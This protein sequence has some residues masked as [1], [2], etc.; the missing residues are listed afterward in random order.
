MAVKIKVMTFNLRIRVINDGK[1]YF[2]FRTDK[3]KCVIDSE[4]PDLIGFQEANDHMADWLKA[5]LSNYVILGHG[6][7]EHYKGEGT[8]VAYRK[9][10]F[11]LHGFREE[12][13]SLFPNRPG[14]RFEGLDQSSCPRVFSRAD[15]IHKDSK[16][17]FAFYNIHTD[18]KGEKV[19]LLECSFLMR[20][21]VST[22]APFVIAGDFNAL[23]DSDSIRL[24]LSTSSEL[25]TVDAT[26]FIRGSFHG[27]RGDVGANKI[28]YIFTNLP[29]DPHR[30]YGV[31]DDDACG[32]YYSDHNALCAFVE[33]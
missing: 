23:P 29:T 12:W 26:R 3:I 11:E 18:H 16:A 6:R 7:N 25:G 1:N 2:D 13:L 5:T 28:D 4:Q 9:D 20:D 24:I 19:R 17:P 31:A 27:F 32:H 22:S 30:S 10:R 15:L 21:V 14:S 33:V 8:Y